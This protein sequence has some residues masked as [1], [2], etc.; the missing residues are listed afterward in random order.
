[1]FKGLVVGRIVRFRT[2]GLDPIA[3]AIVT[4]VVDKTR[5]VVNLQVFLTTKIMPVENVSYSVTHELET[6]HWP[7]RDE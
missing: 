7:P 3:P 1:M 6:W 4:S 5:G 2:A